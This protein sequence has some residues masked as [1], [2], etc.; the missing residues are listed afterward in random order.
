MTET[1]AQR[2]ARLAIFARDAV[3]AKTEYE[4]AFDRTVA[5]TAQLRF[6]RLAREAAILPRV[7]K[8]RRR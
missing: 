4:K 8:K 3:V 6:E 1:L 5:R 7:V 2:K